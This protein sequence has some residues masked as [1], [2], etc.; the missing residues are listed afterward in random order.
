MT[1]TDTETTH[2]DTI[3]FILAH[4]DGGPRVAVYNR[5]SGALTLYRD[6]LVGMRHAMCDRK[7]YAA[8]RRYIGAPVEEVVERVTRWGPIVSQRAIDE[9]SLP[10]D[11][12]SALLRGVEPSGRRETVA[13]TPAAPAPE[14]D[15][16]I[17]WKRGVPPAMSRPRVRYYE[18]RRCGEATYRVGGSAGR[19]FVAQVSS[20]AIYRTPYVR[21]HQRARD[22]FDRLTST[23]GQE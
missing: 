7:H 12:Y 10:D 6:G 21:S 17:K 20:S 8:T 22:L 14:A 16:P 15:W 9:W 19:W 2:H 3:V 11:E 18:T 4:H 13:E 5:S 23:E 1:T